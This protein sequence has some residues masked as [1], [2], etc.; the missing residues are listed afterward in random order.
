MSARGS[1]W[2]GNPSPHEFPGTSQLLGESPLMTSSLGQIHRPQLTTVAQF[3]MVKDHTL[4]NA[5]QLLRYS[6]IS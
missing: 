6:Y 3:A 1:D 5:P 2:V 4:I